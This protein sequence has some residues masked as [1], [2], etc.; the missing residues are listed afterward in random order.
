[1][2]CFGAK[3]GLPFMSD[4]F[5]CVEIDLTA[6]QCVLSSDPIGAGTK[7]CLKRKGFEF[8]CLILAGDNAEFVSKED[9]HRLP[10]W[11]D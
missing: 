4:V 5:V 7:T 9:V 10:S 11:R 1:M 2:L 3:C 6:Q 8:L